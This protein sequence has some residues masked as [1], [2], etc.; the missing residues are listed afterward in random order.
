MHRK[1]TSLLNSYG[2]TLLIIEQFSI[3]IFLMIKL[4][5]KH[6][7]T[8]LKCSYITYIYLVYFIYYIIY[9]IYWFNILIESTLGPCNI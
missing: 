2:V 4:N 6:F 8:D 1:I 7:A 9:L 5:N 3:N